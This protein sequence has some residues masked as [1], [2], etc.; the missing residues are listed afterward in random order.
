MQHEAL[1][2]MA[3]GASNPQIGRHLRDTGLDKA[4]GD[5][6][7]RGAYIVRC[8]LTRLGASGRAHAVDTACRLALVDVLGKARPPE[9]EI[10]PRHKKC[11]VLLA[12]G[13]SYKQ[14]ARRLGLSPLTVK[15][16]LHGLYKRLGASG[17][18]HA[19]HLLHALKEL[20]ADHPCPCRR[21][22]PREPT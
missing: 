5:D 19:V 22:I 6:K 16:H 1:R 9:Q 21:R 18:A 3:L 15:S 2:L 14:A 12:S 4:L 13:L 7:E 17:G 10:L 8:L 11:A 20:P